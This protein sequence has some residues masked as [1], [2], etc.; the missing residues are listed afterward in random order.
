MTYQRKSVM[1][2]NHQ[3]LPHIPSQL[4]RYTGHQHQNVGSQGQQTQSSISP[5]IPEHQKIQELTNIVS[6]KPL[7]ILSIRAYFRSRSNEFKAGKLKRYFQKWKD[8]ASYKEILQ[9]VL[10]LKLGF[11][12]DQP[13][14]YNS[15]F[16]QFSKG[17]ESVINLEIQK[18][19]TKD[20]I[21]KCEQE[22]G[23]HISF[24]F[25]RQKPDDSCRLILNL[26]NLNEDMPLIHSR[27]ETLQSFLSL[28]ISGCYLASLELKHVYYSLPIY[29]DHT[30]ILKFILKNQLYKFLVLP[31][32]LCCDPRKFTKLMNPPIAT[33]R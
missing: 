19:L 21:T 20:V 4:P 29:P 12:G 6:I 16:S 8:L 9:T 30:K 15:Y 28:I 31:N 33:L 22:T 11:L 14:K 2:R 25:I 24:I 27:M 17:D 3:N 32:G 18:V 10:G 13:V 26:K 23:E 1:I 5:T 7:D